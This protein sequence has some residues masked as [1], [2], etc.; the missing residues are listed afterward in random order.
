MAYGHPWSM[1]IG[2]DR[3]HANSVSGPICLIVGQSVQILS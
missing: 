3:D 1:K 2:L